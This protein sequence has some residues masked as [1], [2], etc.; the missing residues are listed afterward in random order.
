MH[1]AHSK[2][3]FVN[4]YVLQIKLIRKGWFHTENENNNISISLSQHQIHHLPSITLPH[5]I[6]LF[7]NHQNKIELKTHHWCCT[8]KSKTWNHQT[9]RQPGKLKQNLKIYS[10]VFDFKKEERERS[11]ASSKCMSNLVGKLVEVLN[12]AI[13]IHFSISLI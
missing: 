6:T 5:V 10:T 7:Q 4:F 13:K 8:H 12:V 1:F 3:N 2:Y 11:W 9:M